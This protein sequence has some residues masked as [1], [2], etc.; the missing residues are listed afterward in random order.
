MAMTEAAPTYYQDFGIELEQTGGAGSIERLRC[1]V[2]FMAGRFGMLHEDI[3]RLEDHEGMLTVTWKSNPSEA[4]K[5]AVQQCW[6]YV[7]E[8]AVEHVVE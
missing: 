7:D 3:A 8:C 6:E 2:A 4:K 5:A 1:V